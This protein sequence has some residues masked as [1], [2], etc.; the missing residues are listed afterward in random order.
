MPIYEFQCKKCDHQFEVL[1]PVSKAGAG[2]KCPKCK[3]AGRRLYTAAVLVPGESS[4]M[5]GGMGEFGGG[6]GGGMGGG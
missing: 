1:R 3:G 5:G 4:D 2:A 6:M